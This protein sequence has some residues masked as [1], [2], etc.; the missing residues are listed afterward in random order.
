MI[1]VHYKSTRSTISIRLWL[2]DNIIGV[3]VYSGTSIDS[4]ITDYNNIHN[5]IN[6]YTDCPIAIH[7]F[8]YSDRLFLYI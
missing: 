7:S 5:T 1:F 3:S 6:K 4:C 2:Y 8:Y